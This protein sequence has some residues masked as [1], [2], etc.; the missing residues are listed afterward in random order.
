M[1]E[2]QKIQQLKKI[3][4]LMDSRF[5]IFG[6]KFGLDGIIG[7]IPFVGDFFTTAISLYIVAQS[8]LLGCSSS[9]LVRM[10]MNIL[11]E[12]LAD[13]I[14]VLGSIFDFVW[15]S[16]NK[17]VELL[18]AHLVNPKK[19]NFQSRLILGLITF[20]VLGILVVSFALT[21]VFIKK[22]LEWFVLFTS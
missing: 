10:G 20:L 12:N 16:N 13:M 1:H 15:K 17:N 8:A 18:E 5:E 2:P 22:L 14:P 7:L 4:I 21:I 3:S 6:F 19:V 9:V 11:I